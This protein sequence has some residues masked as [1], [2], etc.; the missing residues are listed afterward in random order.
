MIA[1]CQSRPSSPPGPGP[2]GPQAGAGGGGRSSAQ[3]VP[4]LLERVGLPAARRQ[5]KPVVKLPAT[6]VHQA[7]QAV[8][9][10]VGGVAVAQAAVGRGH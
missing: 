5:L 1:A 2:T 8:L 7:Q 4:Q 3:P 9:E 10:V 6:Q